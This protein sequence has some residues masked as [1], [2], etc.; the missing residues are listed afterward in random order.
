[1]R[2][3]GTRKVFA[4]GVQREKK[5]WTWKRGS[6]VTR[7]RRKCLLGPPSVHGGGRTWPGI[8]PYLEDGSLGH[9]QIAQRA[10]RKC[11]ARRLKSVS[12][13]AP[14]ERRGF[15]FAGNRIWGGRRLFQADGGLRCQ[16]DPEATVVG[17]RPWEA[18]IAGDAGSRRPVGRPPEGYWVRR[19]E[20]RGGRAR[21]AAAAPRVKQGTVAM[22]E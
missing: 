16:S 20:G 18:E 11:C 5:D 17:L 3:V 2:E 9:A 19:G 15:H 8:G 12:L 1:M 21:W 4:L 7:P 13:R 22:G 10:C 6:H 14:L